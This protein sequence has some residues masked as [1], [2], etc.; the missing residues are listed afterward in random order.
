[1]N[2]ETVDGSARGRN[3]RWSAHCGRPPCMEPKKKILP[4]S[5]LPGKDSL[6]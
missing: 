4:T 6:R 2:D 1:V 5:G 3:K